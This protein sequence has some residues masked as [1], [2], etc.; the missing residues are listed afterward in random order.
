MIFSDECRLSLSVDDQRT[1]VWR[2]PAS[3]AFVV[4]RHT[5]IAQGG[6]V[7][8][9]ISWNPRTL[10]VVLQ[11]TMKARSYVDDS[12]CTAYAIKPPRCHLLGRQRSSTSFVTLP[13]ISSRI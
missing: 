7:W 6:I 1:R 12:G 3:P 8:G 4:E 13:T 2:Q 9:A 11:G 10:L 5:A